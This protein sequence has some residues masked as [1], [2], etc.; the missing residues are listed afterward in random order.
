MMV[1]NQFKGLLIFLVLLVFQYRT[2]AQNDLDSPYTAFGLGYLSNINSIKN[3]SMGSL[4]IG[5]REYNAIN[6][7]N[8]ASYT[9]FDTASFLFEGGVAGSFTQLKTENLSESFTSASISQLTFGFP[10][11][12]WWKN[13][14]G[15]LPFSKVG[16]NVNAEPFQNDFGSIAHNYQGEGGLSRVYW[17]NAFQPFKFLSIGINAS[18]LFGDINR[19]QKVSF[20]DSIY[21]V[22]TRIDN[23]ITYGDFFFEAGVQYFTNFKNDIKFV[24][25]LTYRPQIEIKAEKDFLV[26]SSL[27]ETSNVEFFRD[28]IDHTTSK[29]EVLLPA[30]YGAGISMHKPNHWFVG[31]DYKAEQWEKYKN[32]GENDSLVNSS[33]LSVGGYFIPDYTS[34]SYL[35]RIEY[36]LGG[37]Y[38]NSYLELKD[39]QLS[40][41]GIT[42]GFGLPLRSIALKGSKSMINLGAEIGRR[43]TIE[44]GLIQ[45]SYTNLYLGVSIY[46]FW[47]FKRRYK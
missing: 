20:P 23:S 38:Y 30:G 45:E 7:A 33:S 32:F 16:Y 39:N 18:Y 26:R 41:F 21:Y 44:N 5:T 8:P 17:G 6:I 2:S 29:G 12:S 34:N 9:A 4:G 24:A 14:L 43:G 1:N 36:R 40:G 11:N 3:I 35:K 15:L 31:L 13:S 27:G 47:F 10:I 19:I 46:E 22:N 42:F 37:R 28:T 25:G